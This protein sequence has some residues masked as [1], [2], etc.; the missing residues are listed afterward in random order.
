MVRVV[1]GKEYPDVALF[2]ERV[3]PG[4]TRA[5]QKVVG[6]AFV[7]VRF[8]RVVGRVAH[9]LEQR[10]VGTIA[11]IGDAEVRVAA[12]VGRPGF[13]LDGARVVI[14]PGAGGGAVQYVIA[15]GRRL[16]AGVRRRSLN[17]RGICRSTD[18]RLVERNWNY[19]VAPAVSGVTDTHRQVIPGLPL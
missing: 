10:G 12:V 19:S 4:V 16:A 6:H 17:H 8:Q 2:I 5:H 7:Q 11:D 13:R 18:L 15:V 3:A 14:R 9:R 1:A